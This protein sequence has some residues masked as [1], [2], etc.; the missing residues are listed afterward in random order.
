MSTHTLHTILIAAGVVWICLA[1]GVS[2]YANAKGFPAFPVF[3]SALF[4]GFPLPLL[5]IA[6][7]GGSRNTSHG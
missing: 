2:I 7:G 3:L 1:G 4:L 5:L 6:I